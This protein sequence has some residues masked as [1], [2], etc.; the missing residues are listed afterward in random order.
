MNCCSTLMCAAERCKPR[1]NGNKENCSLACRLTETVIV[2][3]VYRSAVDVFGQLTS[4]YQD[5]E[6]KQL[7]LS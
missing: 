7:I 3:S 1:E 5:S 2:L 6:V 4:R